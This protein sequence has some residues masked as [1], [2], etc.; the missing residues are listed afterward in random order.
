MVK[1]YIISAVRPIRNGWH[2]E[3]NQDLYKN[4]QRLYN[5]SIAS[6]RKFVKEPFEAILLTDPVDDNLTHNIETAKFIKDL[7][8]REPCNILWVGADTFMTQ[9]TEIFTDRFK[10]FR[11][12]NYTDPRSLKAIPHYFNDDVRYYPHTM[13]EETWKVGEDFWNN[14]E[15]S[16]E[17]KE[18]GFDQIKHNAMF[19]SQPIPNEDRLHPHLNYMCMKLRTLD[20]TVIQQHEQ[21]NRAPFANAH[22]LHFCASR[23]SQ[24]VVDLMEILCKELGVEH[25]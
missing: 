24:S 13:S 25:E 14:T 10:E 15:V 23:G 1:N 12:F 16:A 21:W 19:W 3:K 2:I 4:Y 8:H 9:P 11:L 7:W 5:L 20:H 17:L 18:W 22:I 6:Y